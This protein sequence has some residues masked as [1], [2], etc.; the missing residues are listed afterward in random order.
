MASWED[1]DDEPEVGQETTPKTV[2]SD[3][4]NQKGTQANANQPPK[5]SPGPE[6][7]PKP[8]S[9]PSAA[10]PSSISQAYM[11][12]QPKVRIL[13]RQAQPTQ[14][15]RPAGANQGSAATDESVARFHANLEQKQ[16]N[17]EAARKKLFDGQSADE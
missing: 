15:Q 3:K 13:Q 12:S 5:T 9:R 4:N 6:A 14:P 7:P 1:F 8:S 11:T 2:E 17:Y 10:D 16:K